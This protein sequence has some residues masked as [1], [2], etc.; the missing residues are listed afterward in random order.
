MLLGVE[1]FTDNFF[2][3]V[4]RQI[5][6]VF[7]ELD[8]RFGVILFKFGLGPR[9][10]VFGFDAG[11]VL[12]FGSDFFAFLDGIGQALARFGIDIAQ[13]GFILLVQ[14]FGLSVLGVDFIEAGFDAIAA[15]VEKSEQRLSGVAFENPQ[16][17]D[18]A[19]DVR[20]Q[21]WNLDF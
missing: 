15:F 17:D 16:S 3:G 13:F 21:L 2:G 10:D 11:I 1:T 19:D 14:R 4:D 12:D 7:L 8:A 9:H 5:D 6:D 20:Y 18:E